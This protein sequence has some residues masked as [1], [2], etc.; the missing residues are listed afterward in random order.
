MQELCH[1]MIPMPR[2][3]FRSESS[4]APS[5][6]RC[7]GSTV[8]SPA[9]R[10]SN[11]R[12]VP[13]TRQSS[14][15][16]R[17][18]QASRHPNAEGASPKA[19]AS[20]QQPTA[21]VA[22]PKA[23]ASR[24]AIAEGASP[25]AA[26]ENRATS[27]HT[28]PALEVMPAVPEVVP[29]AA[30]EA[31]SPDAAPDAA[32]EASASENRGASSPQADASSQA[33]TSIP[34]KRRKGKAVPS[35]EGQQ[36]QQQPRQ[37]QQQT[38]QPAAASPA[39]GAAQANHHS[40]NRALASADHSAHAPRAEGGKSRGLSHFQRI[41]VG[42]EDDPEFRVVQRLIGPRGKNVQDIV[43]RCNGAKIWII[44]KGSR[45]WEDDAGPLTVCVGATTAPV[46]DYALGLIQDLL[47]K[48]RDDY[49]KFSRGRGG[50][51][52]RTTA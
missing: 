30:P 29:E 48:V 42:I 10:S 18:Q 50:G 16:G 33:W 47:G 15:E 39:R 31:A 23:P 2:P 21:E 34:T 12:Q 19:P 46:F 6:S 25:K 43:S 14:A 26:P 52:S 5:S 45:S 49:A 4:A 28:K 11:S 36:Q 51:A 32:V 9:S 20:R 38:Q 44:G 13:A 1:A 27:Q 40:N 8:E 35:A 41:K 24:Q 7:P 22:P 17:S 3:Q 37:Q